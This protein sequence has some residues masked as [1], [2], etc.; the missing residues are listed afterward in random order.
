MLGRLQRRL[1]RRSPKEGPQDRTPSDPSGHFHPWEMEPLSRGRCPDCG[2]G[3]LVGPRGGLSMNVR[4]EDCG[5]E[6]NI[7]PLGRDRVM[8]HRLRR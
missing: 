8:G 3:L 1:P 7:C 4:C 2:G 5:N 6:F